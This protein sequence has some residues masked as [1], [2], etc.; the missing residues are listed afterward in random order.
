MPAIGVES[1][2]GSGIIREHFTFHDIRAKHLTDRDDRE[3][4]AQLAAGNTDPQTTARYIRNK[5]GRQFQPLKPD[6][7]VKC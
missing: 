7:G 3:L 5:K 6:F 2:L 4:N 1:L